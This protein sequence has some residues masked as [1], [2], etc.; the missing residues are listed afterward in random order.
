MP[1][2]YLTNMS[3]IEEAFEESGRQVALTSVSDND[4]DRLSRKLWT[5]D[6]LTGSLQAVSYTHLTLPTIYSV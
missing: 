3:S 1:V 2:I 5:S 6:Y 4:D